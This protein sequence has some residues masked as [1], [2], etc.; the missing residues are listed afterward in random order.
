MLDISRW[1]SFM[2]KNLIKIYPFVEVYPQPAAKP[3]T[4]A[5]SP[6][7]IGETIEGEKLENSGLKVQTV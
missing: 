6:S 5:H 7:R 4:A 1:T 2:G 3:H